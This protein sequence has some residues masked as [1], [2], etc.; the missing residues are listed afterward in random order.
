M[1]ANKMVKE[2]L[3][4][5]RNVIA[6]CRIEPLLMKNLSALSYREI[7]VMKMTIALMTK[8]D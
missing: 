1:R 8:E 6:E 4:Y 7:E 5:Q 2:K 3:K